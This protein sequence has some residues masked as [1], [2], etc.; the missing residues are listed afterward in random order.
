MPYIKN[1][2]G[3]FQPALQIVGVKNGGLGAHGAAFATKHLDIT[4][5]NGR[6]TGAAKWCCNLQ[7]DGFVAACFH[8]WVT[9]DKEPVYR[10]QMGPYWTTTTVRN[11]KGL[12]QVE[13]T[14]ICTDMRRRGQTY[15]GI[16]VGAVHINE[17]AILVNDLTY[18]MMVSSN[19]PCVEG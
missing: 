8:Q 9:A 3:A 4:V 18:P 14:D 2:I 1:I 7:G 11:G 17:S 15:L 19:T 5:R 12:M 6:I 10:S 16:H 13:V